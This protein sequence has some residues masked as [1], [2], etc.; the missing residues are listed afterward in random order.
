MARIFYGCPSPDAQPP[1]DIFDVIDPITYEPREGWIELTKQADNGEVLLHP[2]VEAGV[3]NA[4]Q[5]ECGETARDHGFTNDWYMAD[6]LEK[7]A[8]KMSGYQIWEVTGDVDNKDTGSVEDRLIE[9]AATLR[10]NIL[11]TKLMLIVSEL[12]EGLESLRHNE[13]AAGALEGKGNFGE[14]LADAIVRILDT[15]T[16][17][18]DNLGDALLRKMAV[19]KD[20]P[21]MHGNKAM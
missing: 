13:G 18:K 1:T 5:Q 9:I 11:G 4:L 17:T 3:V 7:L 2:T 12:S 20:R 21:F 16:F 14:E 6:F 10:T 15:G 19:N 8:T